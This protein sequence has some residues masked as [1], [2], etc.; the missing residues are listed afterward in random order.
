MTPDYP[1]IT[2]SLD[3]ITPISADR[4]GSGFSVLS[5]GIRRSALVTRAVVSARQRPVYAVC[6][7]G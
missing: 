1:H 7:A 4:R 6:L 2:K 3:T 5:L